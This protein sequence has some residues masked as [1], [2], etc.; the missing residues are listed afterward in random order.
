MKTALLEGE[1]PILDM[2]GLVFGHVYYHFK[3]TNVLRTPKAL[4][5][6]YNND[7]PLSKN[8]RDKYK[9]ISADFELQQ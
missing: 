2:L 6:W 1:L 4:I 8:L 9:K 5:N 7:S 3:T